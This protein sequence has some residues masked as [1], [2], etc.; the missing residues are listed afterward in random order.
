[1][2]TQTIKNQRFN[3]SLIMRRAWKFYRKEIDISFSEALKKSWF[4]S[5]NK[6]HNLTFNKV[7]ADH[8]NNVFSFIKTKT[9]NEVAEEIVQDVFV[10]VFE[11][12]DIYDPK[13]SKLITWLYAISNNSITDFFRKNKYK[14]NITHIDNFVND[15]GKEIF[16]IESNL[17][18]LGIENNELAEAV[19]NAMNKLNQK[20]QKIANLYFLQQKQYSEVAQCLDIKLGTVKGTINRIRGKLQ[21]SL[22]YE[23]TML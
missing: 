3:K 10:K 16:E 6:K 13:K 21:E 22:L 12:L 7:Y 4:I 23:Y 9:N 5:K 19:Q 15:Q 17:N 20:E 8:Y 14:N 11:N 2:R 18:E 1:M